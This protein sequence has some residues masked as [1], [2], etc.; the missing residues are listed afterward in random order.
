VFTRVKRE[1]H[2]K[3]NRAKNAALY[4]DIKDGN[5]TTPQGSITTNMVAEIALQ[6]ERYLGLMQQSVR[7]MSKWARTRRAPRKHSTNCTNA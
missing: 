7:S 1:F 4:V 2:E 3:S 5:V 6:N